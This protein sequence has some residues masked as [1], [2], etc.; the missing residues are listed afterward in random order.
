MAVFTRS[1]RSPAREAWRRFARNKAGRIGLI[2]LLVLTVASVVT[3][4]LSI[5][6]Y[7]LQQLDTAVRHSPASSP[8]VDLRRHTEALERSSAG[9]LAEGLAPVGHRAASWLGHDDLGRSL[10]YRLLPGFLVSLA[11]GLAAAAVAVIIGATW[12]ALAALAGGRIDAMMMRIVDVLYSL[13]Y[14][15][16]VILLKIALTRP[17]A[18]LLG[19]RTKYADIIVLFLAIGGVSWLTMARVVR[20][21]VLSLREQPFI[22][23]ARAAGAGWWYILRRHLA[24]NLVG[25]VTVYATLVIPQAILQESFLSFL[26]I[27]VQQPVP[28]L[29]RLAADGV[30][31]VNTFVGFWWLLVFPCGVLVVALFSLNFIG[32]GLRDA[33]DPKS[34]AAT[35][36]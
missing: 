35:L 11:V 13:P 25:P 19:G 34:Q 32:D 5:R 4:P 27:G 26:G 14:I 21:Q 30:Q 6:W 9:K 28:S 16:M 17:L 33:L 2:V 15:L 12:G 1:S 10:L 24:P 7:D 23:A 29:G 18:E 22:E 8:V 31:A 3:L 20:G 36:V